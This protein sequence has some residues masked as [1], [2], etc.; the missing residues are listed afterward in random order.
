MDDNE[1]LNGVNDP[2]D[3]DP[4]VTDTP[5]D[6]EPTVTDPTVTDPTDE[7]SDPI[8]E[9]NERLGVTTA[10]VTKDMRVGDTPQMQKSAPEHIY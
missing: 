3:D 4:V 2:D 10:Y 6:D 9:L 5:T 8:A 7:E 1:L